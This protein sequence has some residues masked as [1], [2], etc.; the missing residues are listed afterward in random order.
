MSTNYPGGIITKNYTAPTPTSASGIWTLEQQEQ[1]QQAGIWPY[2]GPFNYIEDV[3]STYLYTGTG[4]SQTITNNIDLSTNGGMVWLKSRT[5]T[6]ANYIFDT[7]RGATSYLTLNSTDPQYTSAQ[8]LTGFGSSGFTLGTASGPNG[9]PYTYGSWTF[10]K[11]AKFFDIQTYTGT[12]SAGSQTINHNLGST[13]GMIIVKTY[14]TAGENWY[15]YHRSLSTG[16][17]LMF[18]TAA[19]GSNSNLFQSVTSTQ[20]R[21]GSWANYA[22][23]TY[24]MYLYA[25]DA[26]GFGTSNTDNVITCGTYTSAA[27]DL[28]YRDVTLGYEPQFLLV[29]CSSNAATNWCVFDNMRG[30][31][32]DP[33]QPRLLY[34]NLTNAE[35]NGGVAG[36]VTP[37]PTGFRIRSGNA[38]FGSSNVWTYVYV[39][40]RR[41]PMA[42]PTDA[43]KVFKPVT[44]TGDAAASK[45]ISTGKTFPTDWLLTWDRTNGTFGT[46]TGYNSPAITRMIGFGIDPPYLRTNG[47]NAEGASVVKITLNDAQYDYT[48]SGTSGNLNGSA[49]PYINWN[50][51]RAPGFFDVVCYTGDSVAGRQ[52]THNL[53][54][55]P[56]LVIVKARSA[57]A[58]GE[59]WE[60]YWSPLGNI[61]SM[62]IQSTAAR[63]TSTVWNNTSPTSTYFVVGAT[64]NFGSVNYTGYDYVAYLFATCP[65]VSKVGSYTG[66][67]TLTTVDCGFTGG[68]RFV[69]IKRTDAVSD[70]FVWDT[71][72]GM[73]AGTDPSI[74]TNT[75]SPESNANSVYTIAT[76]FQLLAAPSADVNTNGGSYIYL[77]I[78]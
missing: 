54:V 32:V 21:I 30:I 72:R 8:T 43:T 3:F 78:A 63:A 5:Y 66:T 62:R 26:G 67:G 31:Y 74:G 29:K 14:S 15:V 61:R 68:A 51:G 16:E 36:G 27:G 64:G 55:A 73:V 19:K 69:W 13:P 1:A 37:T 65:G 12:D 4:A 7:A 46:G 11:K 42:V 24:V 45:T 35:S 49:L 9:S 10:R 28:S 77:A 40:I 22:G 6:Y 60:S 53:K 20:V 56:D 33:T 71:A 41:G 48:V 39:A 59:N 52:V 50:F 70:W 76:G 2:G 17:Y 75:T 57:L 47:T 44:Y 38:D 58:A 23:L 25:H 34:P 18:T